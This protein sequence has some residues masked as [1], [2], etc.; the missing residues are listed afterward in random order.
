VGLVLG[1]GKTEFKNIEYLDFRIKK[2]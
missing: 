2:N 1:S